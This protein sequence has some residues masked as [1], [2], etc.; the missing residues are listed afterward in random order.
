[1]HRNAKMGHMPQYYD[2][3]FMH[4]AIDLIYKSDKIHHFNAWPD[5]LP[6]KRLLSHYSAPI[7]ISIGCWALLFK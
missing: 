5:Y 7:S 1:M 3:L 2:P 6:S 4:G